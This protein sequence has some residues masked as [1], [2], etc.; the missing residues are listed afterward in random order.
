R[1]LATL[2]EGRHGAADQPVFPG[3]LVKIAFAR[4]DGRALLIPPAALVQRGELRGVY[5]LDDAGRASLRY[6]TVSAPLADGRVPVLSGLTAGERIA[7][8]P[9]A[10]AQSLKRTT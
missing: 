6:V 5:V 9:V 3:T 2:P 1:V 7:V 4:A 8:D 10:A